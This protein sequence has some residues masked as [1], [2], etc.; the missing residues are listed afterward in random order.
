MDR[1]LCA[2]KA[3]YYSSHKAQVNT[4]L[5]GMSSMEVGHKRME[6]S[7]SMSPEGLILEANVTASMMLRHRTVLRQPAQPLLL[8]LQ[9]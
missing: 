2:Q 9:A 3:F 5:L 6:R 7:A 8:S 4:S 1:T